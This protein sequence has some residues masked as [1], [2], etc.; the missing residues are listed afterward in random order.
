MKHTMLVY[1]LFVIIVFC[2]CQ[3][4]I[5]TLTNNE[6]V[7]PP[8]QTSNIKVTTNDKI[9]GEYTEVGYVFAFGSSVKES[10][11]NL[12]KKASEIGG[13]S[14]IKLQTT[15]IR[16]FIVIIFIPIPIDTYYAQG[17]VVKS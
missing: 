13:T 6:K 11:D 16:T 3:Q 10:V 2:G 5:Y 17:I 7:Y 9:D 14:V 1:T 8:T 12:R 4:S 15:V